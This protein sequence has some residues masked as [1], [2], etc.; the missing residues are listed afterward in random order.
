MKTLFL[1]RHAKSSWD[2]P[3]EDFDRSLNRRGKENAKSM[4]KRLKKYQI[5]P[6]LVYSSPAKRAKMTAKTLCEELDCDDKIVYIDHLYAALPETLLD[7]IRH[8][9]GKVD[10]L[11]LI[12]HNPGLNELAYEL[13]GFEENLVTTGVLHLQFDTASW[14]DID[15]SNAVLKNVYFPKDP[16]A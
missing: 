4:G 15:P 9:P 6:D 14:N 7:T 16:D 2:E 1:I 11:F 13:V 3:V 12:A 8:A 5:K 10:T